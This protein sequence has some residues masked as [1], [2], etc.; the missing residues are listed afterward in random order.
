MDVK[1]QHLSLLEYV[2]AGETKKLKI[3]DQIAPKWRKVGEILGLENCELDSIQ[4]DREDDRGKATAVL[5]KW[6][7]NANNL[8]RPDKYPMTW[9]GLVTLLKDCDLG[10][11]SKTVDKALNTDVNSVK[12]NMS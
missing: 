7:E 10:T 1:N 6:M 8:A 12:G 5:Q 11:L 2:D 3:Y 9:N 4:H